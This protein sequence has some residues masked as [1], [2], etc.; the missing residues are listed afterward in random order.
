LK[1]SLFIKP[2]LNKYRAFQKGVH[3][4][5]SIA[6]LL[7]KLIFYVNLS[8]STNVSRLP[9]QMCLKG[10]CNTNPAIPDLNTLILSISPI[11][12]FPSNYERRSPTV[13]TKP[14][15]HA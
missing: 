8:L 5:S 7:I 3:T 10:P 1:S 4:S 13:Y 12:V 14:D 9:N 6:I 15:V 2:R 11:F